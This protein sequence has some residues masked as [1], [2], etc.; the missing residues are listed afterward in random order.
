M[1]QTHDDF[2]QK[3]DVVSAFALFFGLRINESNLRMVGT[4]SPAE[5]K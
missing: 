4:L 3:I 5:K 2:Q 1:A